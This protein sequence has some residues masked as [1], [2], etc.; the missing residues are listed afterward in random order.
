MFTWTS[1]YPRYLPRC[2]ISVDNLASYISRY[3]S[4]SSWE[5]LNLSFFSWYEWRLH[6]QLLFISS[7]YSCRHISLNLRLWVSQHPFRHSDMK[8]RKSCVLSLFTHSF[9]LHLDLQHTLKPCRNYTGSQKNLTQNQFMLLPC[10][11]SVAFAVAYSPSV[12]RDT[13]W[14][15]YLH[16][17]RQKSNIFSRSI[18]LYPPQVLYMAWMPCAHAGG[19]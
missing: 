2:S 16:G 11:R 10:R 17:L 7:Q 9:I 1:F 8:K 18:S 13:D 15:F 6:P 5:T 14:I 3:L 19:D 4:S 12:L